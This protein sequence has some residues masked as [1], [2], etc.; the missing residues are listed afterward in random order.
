MSPRLRSGA[1]IVAALAVVVATAAVVGAAPFLDGLA[2]VS[3]WTIVA[4]VALAAAATAA[5]AWRWQ[6]V[7]TGFGLPLTWSDAFAAYYRSQF[8]NMVL[9]GGVVGDVQRAYVQGRV[10]DRL[11]LAA[12]AVAAERIAGQ[13]VQLVLTLAIL[14]PLGLTSPLAPLAWIS[15]AVA[16]LMLVGVAV[17]AL[18]G[19]GRAA[20]AREYRMLRPVLSRPPTLLAITAASVVVLAAHTATFVVAGLAAGARADPAE[21]A[22]VALIVLAAAAIP[23]NVG[24]WGPREAVAAAAFALAG[25]G[26]GAGVAVSTAFGVLTMVA[27]APGAVALLADRFRSSRRRSMIERRRPV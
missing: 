14:L 10:H 19:R 21:L 2:A 11:D 20:L 16:L 15:G 24:G 17:V 4:A 22:I 1:R 23:L 27:V 3:P 26:A 6:M 7:S 25:L 9:P 8:L 5:A 13:L 18:S 12:R